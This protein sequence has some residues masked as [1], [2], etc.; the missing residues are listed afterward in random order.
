M[1]SD[2]FEIPIYRGNVTMYFGENLEFIQKEYKTTDLSN[3]GAVTLDNPDN[4]FKNY[5]VAFA[6]ID[7]SL[8]AH[9][10]VHIK[11]H[12][13]RDCGLELDRH[14]DEAEA[15]LTGFLFAQIESFLNKQMQ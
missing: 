14:N 9:E 15:Y 10:V 2:K 1:V 12:I 13:F 8:V 11:N 6:C 7:F 5:I 4:S 3:Y